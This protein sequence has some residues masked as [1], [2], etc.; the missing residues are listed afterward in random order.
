MSFDGQAELGYQLPELG[1]TAFSEI[2]LT[3]GEL[4]IWLAALP[5]LNTNQLAYQIPKYI[6]DLNRTKLSDKQRFN[7]LEQLR[8]LVTHIFQ[9]L[10]KRFRGGNLSLSAESQEIQWLI[11]VLMSEMAAGY[12]RLLFNIAKKNPGLFGRSQYVLLT[13]RAAYYLGEKICLAYLLSAVVPENVWQEFNSTYAYAR[14]FKLNTK[15][16]NDEFA[17]LDQKKGSIES[18]YNR[19][20]LLT[21]VS[22]YSLR[23]AELEQ[24]YFGLLP[25][26][27]DIK[28]INVSEAKSNVHVLNLKQDKGPEFQA[29]V[30]KGEDKYI[31]DCTELV[32]KLKVWLET[33]A[34]P[35][36]AK[37]KGMSKKLLIEIIAKLD[38]TK[39]RS[40]E[41]LYNEG[42]RVEVVIG[43]EN[44]DL[45]LGHITSL[46]EDHDSPI[47]QMEIDEVENDMIWDENSN[48]D[49]GTLH[50][51]AP[52]ESAQKRAVPVTPIASVKKTEVRRHVFNIENESERGVCLSCSHLHGT[53]L[54]IGELMFIRGFDPET[55]TLGIIRWMTL[56][57]KKLE[58][59]LFLLSAHVDQVVVSRRSSAGDITV[60]ALWMA[61]GE[62]GDTILLPTAEF[63]V[64]DELQLDHKGDEVDISLGK[65]VWHSEG[66][67]Q[68][69]MIMNNYDDLEFKNIE[70]KQ[71]FLIPAWA[72]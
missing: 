69:C 27:H 33:G 50:F 28:L 22:P 29:S 45:F 16:L 34:A 60:N 67:S 3:P 48:G 38:S 11:N 36:S 18:I 37:K 39:Q 20:L 41:R 55:W 1:N 8:P 71:D 51:Y 52:Q 70:S 2:P 42:G 25:W 65:V 32:E 6:Q 57:N 49:W 54:Y 30:L 64:G 56:Q 21:L 24:V 35:K 23:S 17:F 58:V 53:G 9:S 31:L 12:Q 4:E 44:I 68:F 40:E 62:H 13:Q 19:I 61:K 10:T 14:K 43:L 7:M 47:P 66:F 46:I 72:K 5:I 26:L 63:A 15:K 59:G